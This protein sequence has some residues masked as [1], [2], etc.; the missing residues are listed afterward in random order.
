[1]GKASGDAI[2]KKAIELVA[3]LSAQSIPNPIQ[4]AASRI[5][6]SASVIRNWVKETKK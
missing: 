2:K 5:G 4:V 1:M 3:K 6:V